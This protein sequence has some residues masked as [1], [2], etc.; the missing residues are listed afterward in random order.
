MFEYTMTKY[1]YTRVC[2]IRT[3]QLIDGMESFVSHHKDASYEEIISQE[4]YEKKMPLKITRQIG[5]NKYIDIPISE[6]DVSKYVDE[7]S[8]RK[9]DV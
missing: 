8:F 5:F 7:N 9:M 1:E 4:L 6:L 2:G 3:Q